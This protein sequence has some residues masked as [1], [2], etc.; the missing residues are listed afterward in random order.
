MYK[1]K[2]VLALIPARGGSKRIPKKNVKEL[3]GKPLIGYSIEQAISATYVDYVFVSTDNNEIAEVSKRFGAEIIERPDQFAT[4]TAGTLGVMKHALTSLE[5]KDLSPD[6]VVILQPTSPLRKA[7]QI[8]EA[9]ASLLDNN[10]DTV[11]GVTKRHLSPKWILKKQGE[12]LT[13]M[14][15]NAFDTIRSQD[16]EETFEINGALYAYTKEVILSSEKYAWGKKILPIVMSKKES[17]DIDEMEDFEVA[18][19]LLRK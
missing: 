14:Q 7:E 3:A 4:D 12:E 9:I 19:A 13:F 8:N 1:D 16:Q 15:D 18:E 5:E 11:L 2:K 6:I 10:A 17:I